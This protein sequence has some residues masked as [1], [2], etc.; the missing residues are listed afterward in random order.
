MYRPLASV[1]V[2]AVTSYRLSAP[3][4]FGR[5]VR[6]R[7]LNC[8]G[9]LNGQKI[10]LNG[11]KIALSGIVVQTVILPRDGKAGDAAQSIETL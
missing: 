8:G 4:F 3:L 2:T 7:W 11:Q 5:R 1:A 9:G 10:A 6:S